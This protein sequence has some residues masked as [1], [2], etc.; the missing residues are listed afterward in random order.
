MPRGQQQGSAAP[1]SA[2]EVRKAFVHRSA[3][4]GTSATLATSWLVL[5]TELSVPSHTLLPVEDTALPP[6][7][8]NAATSVTSN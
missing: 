7:K 8:G 4:V 2:L 3:S 1:V 6:A 5:D